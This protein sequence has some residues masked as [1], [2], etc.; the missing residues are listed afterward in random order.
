[1]LSQEGRS[2]SASSRYCYRKSGV[3]LPQAI[4]VIG[5]EECLA[6]RE[7]VLLPQA[8]IVIES[9]EYFGHKPVLS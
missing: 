5:I 1:M 9:Q 7:G 8:V 3:L 4:I 2:T 6:R